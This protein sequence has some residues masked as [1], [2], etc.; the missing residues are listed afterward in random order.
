VHVL[1][2]VLCQ[3]WLRGRGE[4]GLVGNYERVNWRERLR[5]V[6]WC[7]R[8]FLEL[9]RGVEHH[10]LGSRERTWNWEA[11]VGIA[12]EIVWVVLMEV[13][14]VGVA[15]AREVIVR[16]VV[17]REAGWHVVVCKALAI[18]SVWGGWTVEVLMVSVAVGVS[19]ASA[20]VIAGIT[21]PGRELTT[22]SGTGIVVVVSLAVATR[23]HLVVDPPGLIARSSL[24]IH[25][26]MQVEGFVEIILLL[27]AN[28]TEKERESAYP[29]G[30]L[31]VAEE[32]KSDSAYQKRLA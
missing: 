8:A 13:A 17:D 31:V 19:I 3:R 12:L 18:G 20:I 5:S 11:L 28:R 16:E 27:L 23:C 9:H 26:G 22:T 24:R 29:N 21:S 14:A 30:F 10:R 32:G 6:V 2:L 7:R 4:A 1:R 25:G 15:V